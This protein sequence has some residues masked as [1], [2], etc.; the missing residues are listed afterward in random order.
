MQ[1][2]LQNAL[3]RIQDCCGTALST[4]YANYSLDT[5][6]NEDRIDRP[7]DRPLRSRRI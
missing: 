7:F 6:E 5:R 4:L 2:I 1:N 3:P